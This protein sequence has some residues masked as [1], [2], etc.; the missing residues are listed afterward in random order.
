MR[1]APLQEMAAIT[2]F[3]YRLGTFARFDMKSDTSFAIM[4]QVT[5]ANSDI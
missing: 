2:V 4:S 5:P 1:T 3:A